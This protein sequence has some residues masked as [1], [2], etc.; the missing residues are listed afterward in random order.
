MEVTR[1]I[2]S[3]RRVLAETR[4]SG[5]RIAFVPTMGALHVAHVS[6]MKAAKH[7]SGYLVVSIF[8]NP[9]QFAR[10][11]VFERYARD[12]AGDL[13]ICQ[14]AGVDLVFIPPPE[15]M[16]RPDATTT[17]HVARLTDTLCG[18]CR[19][20]HFDGVTLVVAK[21]FNIVQPDVTYFG[22]KDFQQLAVIRRMVRD[23]DMPI[24][25]VGCPTIRE[26]DGLAV[27]SRN[28]YLTD[29]QRRQA[30]SLYRSLCAARTRIQAG[31]R[32]PVELAAHMRRIID[33]AGPANVDYISVVDPDSMQ[34][35]QRIDKPVLIAL[36]V[37]VGP[38]RL[39]DNLL[40]D[41]HRTAD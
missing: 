12:E 36:A 31:A 19:P 15:A 28:A 34:P 22:E 17:V 41:P 20:G 9:T 39:I 26:P 38:A 37:H 4:R 24:E 23:L 13:E 10:G 1:E 40:V 32:N 16:Y 7:A 3:A 27:S 33:E 2:P 35:V 8:V 6:L 14:K 18:P 30:T 11:G 21:L 25:I 29:A 5:R